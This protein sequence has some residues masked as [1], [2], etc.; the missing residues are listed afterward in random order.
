MIRQISKPDFHFIQKYSIEKKETLRNLTEMQQSF[1]DNVLETGGDLKKSAELAGYK[2]SPNQVIKSLKGELVDLAQDVLAH[3][4][5]K[6]A[7]KLVSMLDTDRPIP[8]ASNKLQA[9][10]AILDRVGVVKQEK[11]NVD[12]KVTGG[13]FIL[14]WY[15][16]RTAKRFLSRTGSTWLM[17]SQSLRSCDG[18]RAAP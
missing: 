15:R 18:A 7:F 10:Q 5:P 3:S 4:A 14:G 11:V 1:L 2:G 17:T 13:L 6:A 8:Q 9:A 12:H 16:T